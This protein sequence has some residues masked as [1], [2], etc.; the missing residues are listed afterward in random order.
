MAERSEDLVTL[1]R[2]SGLFGVRGWVKVYSHTEPRENIVHYSPWRLRLGSGWREFAVA[3]G[4]RHGKGVIARLDGVDD[5]N[6][7]AALVGAEVAVRRDQLPPL[8]EDEYYWSDLEGLEVI[9]IDGWHLGRVDHLL[10]TGANDVLVVH[11]DRER[12]IP[13]V[14]PDVVTAV[15]LDAAV[16][17][18]DWDPDF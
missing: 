18:V 17:R 7:A 10:E 1:G 13:F 14:R 15:D 16:I 3:D 2:I 11:G 9:T 5:R 4:Q 12:L 8:G 6:A